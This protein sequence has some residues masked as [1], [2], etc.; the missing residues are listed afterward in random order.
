MGVA[1]GNAGGKGL[2]Y[3]GI[4]PRR[5]KKRRGARLEM[6]LVAIMVNCPLADRTLVEIGVH[7]VKGW[8]KSGVIST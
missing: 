8:V 6:A 5:T 3:F 7:W 1:V 4:A 2:R